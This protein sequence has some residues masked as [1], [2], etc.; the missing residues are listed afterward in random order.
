MP[1]KM[2]MC[3]T[4]R[5]GN[6][7]RTAAVNTAAGLRKA[8]QTDAL[9]ATFQSKSTPSTKCPGCSRDPLDNNFLDIRPY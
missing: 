5:F 7:S 2:A 1:V 4:G 9:Q 8:G 6:E 3:R